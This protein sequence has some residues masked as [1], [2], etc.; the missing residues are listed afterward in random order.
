MAILAMRMRESF[1]HLKIEDLKFKISAT[2]YLYI[3]LCQP[4]EK[5]Q[6]HQP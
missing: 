2:I 3:A 6:Q 4:I 5:T 1:E